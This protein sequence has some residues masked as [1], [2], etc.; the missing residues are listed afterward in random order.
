[1]WARI[2]L[3]LSLFGLTSTLVSGQQAIVPADVIINASFDGKADA[4]MAVGE[5]TASVFGNV[6][7]TKG[8]EG[9]AIVTGQKGNE[10]SYATF[11]T[12]GNINLPEG[13]IEMWVKPMDWSGEDTGS[14]FF[15]TADGGSEGWIYLYKFWQKPTQIM[16]WIGKG[17][18]TE[19]GDWRWVQP[20]IYGARWNQ[21][22][23]HH[24]VV[25]WVK[26]GGNARFY[27]DGKLC[28]WPPGDISIPDEFVPES[29]GDHFN[30][31]QAL[32]WGKNNLAGFT[33]IDE[34][35]I[36]KRAISPIEVKTAFYRLEY[37]KQSS[38]P[39]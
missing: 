17:G 2:L 10:R 8:K 35:Y 30:I 33:A 21:G 24:L 38:H 39:K 13:T 37:F 16:L 11:M 19:N 28:N 32:N 27:A 4:D 9:K 23:W 12:K 22:E 14:Q 34:L 25:T 3:V 18:K 1:M 36:Y 20:A 26:G 6:Y 7:Y 5:K 15:F 29:V 31:G